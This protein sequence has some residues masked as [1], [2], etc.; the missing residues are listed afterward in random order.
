MCYWGVL[1]SAINLMLYSHIIIQTRYLELK[2]QG[3]PV[4]AHQHNGKLTYSIIIAGLG[5]RFLKSGCS[6][7]QMQDM[8]KSIV[9]LRHKQM[10]LVAVKYH[11]LEQATPRFSWAAPT[12]WA[13]LQGRATT[14]EPIN[15]VALQQAQYFLGSPWL[16]SLFRDI[17]GGETWGT[18]SLGKSPARVTNDKPLD[19]GQWVQ[20][21][22]GPLRMAYVTWS[23][24]WKGISTNTWVSVGKRFN[25]RRFWMSLSPT[26]LG[27]DK[28]LVGEISCRSFADEVEIP[29]TLKDFGNRTPHSSSQPHPTFKKAIASCRARKKSLQDG[30]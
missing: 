27:K 30:S 2:I 12:Q 3:L 22:S 6:L 29:Q 14:E 21:R 11:H 5:P 17:Y 18:P 20:P 8:V 13:E 19:W 4:P 28:C 10:W 7:Q 16:Q 23:T 1:T 15:Q 26:H 25:S 24:G 9:W